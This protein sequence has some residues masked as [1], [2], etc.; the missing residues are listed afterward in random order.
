MDIKDDYAATPLV[1]PIINRSTAPED[2]VQTVQ[3]LRLEMLSQLTK[4][5]ISNDPDSVKGMRELMK[6]LV[7]TAQTTLKINV[8]E[9]A[10][11]VAARA[12]DSVQDIRRL[13]GDRNP[14]LVNP[15]GSVNAETLREIKGQRLNVSPEQLPPPRV[16]PGMD[17]QGLDE[18]SPDDFIRE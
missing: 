13:Y 5:G 11:D 8:E 16:I 15:D 1:P 2:V 4:G 18:V 7:G 12:V 10:A 14:F 17:K 3:E 9:K 6:D